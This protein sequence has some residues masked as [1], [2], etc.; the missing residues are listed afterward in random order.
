MSPFKVIIKRTLANTLGVFYRLSGARIIYFHSVHPTH[1][2]AHR[3][4]VFRSMLNVI[5]ESDKEVIT[6]REMGQRLRANKDVKNCISINFDDGYAD[7]VE[8]A[9]PILLEKGFKA[10][11]FIA[12]GL[13]KDNQFTPDPSRRSEHHCYANLPMMSITQ[14]KELSKVGMEV[15]SHTVSHRYMKNDNEHTVRKELRDSKAQLEDIIGKEVVSFAFPNGEVPINVRSQDILGEEGYLQAV[16]TRW[17]CVSEK[18]DVF[19]LPRQIVD[20][21]ED[22]SDFRVKIIGKQDYMKLYQTLRSL[23]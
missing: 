10:T 18:T 14:V 1:R 12:A 21:Y 9:L 3:P 16:T 4:E 20:V 23:R 8:I 7:N 2:L 11:F 17:D 5:K 22:E 19:L 13:I 6:I 15:G